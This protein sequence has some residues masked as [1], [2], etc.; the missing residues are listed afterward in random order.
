MTTVRTTWAAEFRD[1]LGALD[2]CDAIAAARWVTVGVGRLDAG[3]V[4]GAMR[5]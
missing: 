1:A 5:P 3:K 2:G 4:F